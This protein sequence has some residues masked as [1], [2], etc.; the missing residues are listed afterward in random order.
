MLNLFCAGKIMLPVQVNSCLFR[1]FSKK[2]SQ[3]SVS[4]GNFYQ[5]SRLERKSLEYD[6]QIAKISPKSTI[7]WEWDSQI[8]HFFMHAF[9]FFLSLYIGGEFLVLTEWHTAIGTWEC[10]PSK[11]S[12]LKSYLI[13]QSIILCLTSRT[14]VTSGRIL[15][16]DACHRKCNL[17]VF[18]CVQR[19]TPGFIHFF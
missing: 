18:S 14:A 17:C 8:P 2:I 16:E 12:N 13:N 10:F 1:P 7:S 3:L 9:P 11:L 6:Q 4:A 15:E 19:V 5:G